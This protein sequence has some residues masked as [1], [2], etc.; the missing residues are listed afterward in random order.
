M[1]RYTLKSPRRTPSYRVDYDRELNDQ[2]RAVVMAGEGP[3]LVI[4]G[5]GSGKTRAL[6]YRVGRLIES[7]EPPEGILLLTFTNKAAREMLH[8]VAALLRGDVRRVWGGTFHHTGNLILR[9]FAALLGFQPTYTI[10][11]R[12]DAAELIQSCVAECSLGGRGRRFPRGTVLLELFNFASDTETTLEDALLA[13]QP[14]HLDLLGEM[15]RVAA[16]YRERKR[17]QNLMDFSDLLSGWRTLLLEQPPARRWLQ[18][19]FRHILVDEYQDTNRIQG[20]VVDLMAEAHRNL[21]V[22]GDDAQ[23]IYSFRG[24]HFANII[25]FPRRYPDSSVFRLEA[26]YRSVPPILE[27]ANAA[28]APNR[29]QFPKRL[30]P[31][32]QGGVRPVL[33][34]TRDVLQQADFVAQRVLELQDEGIPLGEMA[35]LYRAHYHSME[36]QMELTRRGIP[37]EVRSGLRFFEQRHIKDVTAYLRIA[38]NPQ[39]ELAWKR[40]LKLQPGIGNAAAE[41]VWR[42]VAASGD[43]CGAIRRG[44]ADRLFGR[45]G[46]PG[47]EAHKRLLLELCEEPLRGQP[48][49]MIERALEGGYEEYLQRNFPDAFQRAEDVR[50]LARFALQYSSAE[51]LLSELALLGSVGSEVFVPGEEGPPERLI[52]STVHQAKGLEWKELFLIW[53]TEGRFPS[54]RALRDPEGEEEERRLF[55]VA[56]TRAKD[57]LFLCYPL[58]EADTHRSGTLAKPSRFLQDIPPE[59]YEVWQLDEGT[60]DPEGTPPGAEGNTGGRPGERTYDHTFFED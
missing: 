16:R 10:L 53:L 51:A 42:F 40:T 20:E 24:A 22:V 41:R 13:R 45:S 1:K 21:T 25:E 48:A 6:T 54:P 47:W 43:P 37:F 17:A 12:E 55:Y 4:A 11:D 5:A 60:G 19:R 36:L 32:R 50:Q 18:G 28:I 30:V 59:C 26:N 7:G 2:Q 3:I 31:I 34:P 29:R 8:R 23:S 46:R 56:I 9:R 27:L 15:E 49:A 58:L 14:Y 38:T 52:L 44:E 39:D 35:V 33:V 57:E